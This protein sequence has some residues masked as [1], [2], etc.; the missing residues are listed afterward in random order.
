M[1]RIADGDV[2]SPMVPHDEIAG[3]AASPGRRAD[4]TAF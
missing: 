1:T 3:L 4:G 2:A